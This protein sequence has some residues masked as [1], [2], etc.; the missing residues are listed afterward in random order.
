MREDV[1]SGLTTI[2]HFHLKTEG[3]DVSTESLLYFIC[4]GV[5]G[6]DPGQETV[7]QSL[8]GGF[9]PSQRSRLSL[10]RHLLL[11]LLDSV[12]DGGGGL[13]VVGDG[14]TVHVKEDLDKK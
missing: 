9:S 8:V 7:G 5:L 11:G 10:D 2:S 1:R 4:S 12:H 13:R 6:V 14:G 3:V